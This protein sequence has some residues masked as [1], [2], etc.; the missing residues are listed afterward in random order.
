LADPSAG[1]DLTQIE[2]I[3]NLANYFKHR[4]EWKP[5][6]SKLSGQAGRTATLV[7]KLGLASGSTGNLKQGARKPGNRDY[8]DLTVFVEVVDAWAT[9]VLTLAQRQM[10]EVRS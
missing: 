9:K 1:T 2:A 6:W 4:S 5:D 3:V 10:A 8:D 7:Q